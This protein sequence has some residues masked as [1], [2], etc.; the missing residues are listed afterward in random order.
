MITG[1][2]RHCEPLGEAI[3]ARQAVLPALDCHAAKARLAM[4]RP[5]CLRAL[6]FKNR[7][8]RNG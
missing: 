8:T 1:I 3:Q 2:D 4:T 5:S 6:L 7:R